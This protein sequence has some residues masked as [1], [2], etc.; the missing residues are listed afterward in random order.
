MQS[1]RRGWNVVAGSLLTAGSLL[2]QSTSRVS[3]STTGAQGD[4]YSDGAAL[5]ADGRFIAFRSQ[6]SSL[7][8][9][10]PNWLFHVFVRDVLTGT[11][12][13]LSVDPALGPGDGHS[14]DAA[15]SADGRFVAFTSHASNLVAGDAGGFQ[16]IFVRDRQASTTRCVSV[17]S[18]GVQA[19]F[20]SARPSI[21]ADG[22]FVAFVSF[23]SNLVPGD[24][25]G[26]P[27]VFVHDRSDGTTRRVSVSTSGTQADGESTYPAISGDGRHV[28]FETLATNLVAGDGNGVPDV[29]VR[30]LLTSTTQRASVST[31]GGDPNG[32]SSAPSISADGRF[33]AF[34]SFASNL[35]AGDFNGRTDVFVVDLHGATTERISVGP[36]GQDANHTSSVPRISADGR[37]VTFMSDASNLVGGDSNATLDCFFRDRF[38]S[39]TGRASLGASGAQGNGISLHPAISADGR[40]VGFMSWATNLVSG[41]TNAAADVFVRDLS[42]PPARVTFCAGDGSGAACPCAPGL[43]GQG[44]ANSVNA[45]G[46]RLVASGASTTHADTLLLT[47]SGMPESSALFFQGTAPVADGAGAVFGDGVRCAGGSILR[48][49]IRTNIGGRSQFPDAGDPAVSVRGQVTSPGVRV[50][51]VWYR[52]AAAFCTAETFN[53]TN[54]TRV[55]WLAF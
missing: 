24:T 54:G 17:D 2:G 30:D 37:W 4:A 48:L 27:D 22:R 29:L 8:V 16:D 47:A 15:L 52:D 51:Q 3:V 41:D 31:Q 49:A 9:A 28:A 33:V 10:N 36:S 55:T 23:A 45:G 18:T 21:S 40:F 14:F 50:Y 35:V 43:P 20:H 7:G 46:A 39:T 42:G 34:E 12:E 38:T 32:R 25:N 53:L 6:A 1:E 5:S 26:V 13:C 11:T 19:N 44:C